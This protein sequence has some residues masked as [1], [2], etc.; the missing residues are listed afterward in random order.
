MQLQP[1]LTPGLLDSE[2]AT[3]LLRP[4]V[5]HYVRLEN[6]VIWLW[7]F[8]RQDLFHYCPVLDGTKLTNHILAEMEKSRKSKTLG[9]TR[10]QESDVPHTWVFF[11]FHHR[12][13]WQYRFSGTRDITD[14]FWRSDTGWECLGIDQRKIPLHH[15][16]HWFQKPGIW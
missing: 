16:Y 9:V 8:V 5:V 15:F 1:H 4:L 11:F 6:Q 12:L 7:K 3:P 13:K 2:A 10:F 14:D